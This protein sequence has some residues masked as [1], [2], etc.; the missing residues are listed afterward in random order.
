MK[1]I[2][3]RLMENKKYETIKR[4]VEKK[5]SR[6]RVSV[7][8]DLSLRQV[9]R[10]VKIYKTK[11]KAGFVHGNRDRK[12]AITTQSDTAEKILALYQEKYN[13]TNFSHFREKLISCENIKISYS[14]LRNLLIK[15][16]FLSP[17]AQRKT[18]KK[19]AILKKEKEKNKEETEKESIEFPKDNIVPLACSHPRKER[20]KYFGEEIQKDASPH[21][22]FGG[23]V[24]HLH[25]AID[26]ATKIIVGGYFD[27]QETLYAY[28]N[29]LFQ[30]LTNYGIPAKLKTDN[31]TVFNYRRLS[32]SK[33]TAEKDVSTQYR[34][35][36][37]QLGIELKTTSVPQAKGQVE[38]LNQTLQSRLVPELRL[39]NIKTIDEANR[40]LI[41]TFIP[42][43]NKQFGLDTSKFTSVFEKAPDKEKINQILA[44]I[45]H[46]VV[47]S[48]NSIKFKNNYYQ[49]F[50]NNKLVC[51][52]K[53]TK[54]LVIKTFDNNL[55]LSIDDK[56]YEMRKLET[57]KKI[58]ENFDCNGQEIYYEREKLPKAQLY[59]HYEEF[60]QYLEKV[61]KDNKYA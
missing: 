47:D 59:W 61:R 54:C 30:I 9:D 46:R 42:A 45:D 57:N 11:G 32:E 19:L 24:T 50:S 60:M 15:N 27:M 14:P 2:K 18:R 21:V 38:R 26:N 29:V 48:G 37:K 49:P 25:L 22:W 20:A 35:A 16:G 39:Q 7:I 40:F 3:L 52:K 31:R 44:I 34:Y 4:L 58:S 10:L 13:D 12:P 56:I 53:G 1:E 23:F 43:Y 17:K 51:F 36:C 28:Q 6:H 5:T 55:I 33:Q 8:L 41:E